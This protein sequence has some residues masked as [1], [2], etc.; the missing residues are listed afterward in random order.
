MAN[1][2]PINIATDTPSSAAA[3][4]NANELAINTELETNTTATALNTAKT[5]I[6]TDQANDIIANNA[7]PTLTSTDTLV[8]K[9]LTSP[10]VNTPVV[11]TPV[12]NT[13]ISGTAFLD[14]DDFS[15]NSDNKVASQQSIKSYVDAQSGTSKPVSF[16]II[17]LPS[18][19]GITYS[20]ELF[21]LNRQQTTF[22]PILDISTPII[23]GISNQI[24]IN[25]STWTDANNS[26]GGVVILGDFV[27]VMLEDTATTPDTFRVYRYSKSN[28][29][30]TGTLMS[31]SGS[32]T[33]STTNSAMLINSDGTNFYFSYN[34]GNSSNSY[35]IAKYT[36]SGT[37]FTYDSTITLSDSQS[38]NNGYAIDISGN[39]FTMNSSVIRKYNSSG[40]LQFTGVDNRKEDTLLNVENTLYTGETNE[41]RYIRIN[42]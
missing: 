25:S 22:P 7:K 34:A 38:F 24:D 13:S 6:T 30:A 33:L 4:T 10:V 11:N 19:G 12:L 27:Y 31:F 23:G 2:T 37:T 26:T 17:D 20:D 21:N 18:S 41:H 28:I 39:I 5:G 9:T 1:I 35:E 16:E 14:E 3:R 29:T 8:N 36:L 40:V 42:V 15:S 32:T